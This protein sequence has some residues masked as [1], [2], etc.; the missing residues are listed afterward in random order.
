M[1][2]HTVNLRIITKEEQGDAED[3]QIM[4]AQFFHLF[5][6]NKGR[7]GMDSFRDYQKLKK[8]VRRFHNRP[9][10]ERITF[11]FERYDKLFAEQFQDKRVATKT[12]S[13]HISAVNDQMLALFKSHNID[14][15]IKMTPQVKS[16]TNAILNAKKDISKEIRNPVYNENPLIFGSNNFVQVF[17]RPEMQELLAKDLNEYKYTYMNMVEQKASD[18]Q[19]LVYWIQKLQNTD[20]PIDLRGVAFE[21]FLHYQYDTPAFEELLTNVKAYLDGSKG[22]L[23]IILDK[24]QGFPT[25]MAA[26]ERAK[27]S[28]TTVYRGLG[29]RNGEYGDEEDERYVDEVEIISRERDNIYV[30]TSTS[31][32]AATNF[33]HMKGHLMGGRTSDYG[34]M[35]TYEVG[36]ESILFDTNIFGGKFDEDEVVIDTRKAKLVNIEYDEKSDEEDDDDY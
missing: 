10:F 18:F 16:Y 21:K 17:E 32:H 27:N 31:I 9:W 36:P 8:S 30:A 5:Q 19:Y 33:L 22:N 29:F 34:Y 11:F 4:L 35:L 20:E 25:I 15:I 13:S 2:Y 23:K 3:F 7:L 6:N 12:S 26:N 1:K 28:I 14:A 24:M